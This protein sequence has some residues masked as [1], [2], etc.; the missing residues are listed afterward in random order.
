MR[1]VFAAASSSL[2]RFPLGCVRGGG[3][4]GRI[5]RLV[6]G[7]CVSF[8][9][10]KVMSQGYSS[11]CA[12]ARDASVDGC[13][14]ADLIGNTPL[15]YLKEVSR[16]CGCD[17]FAKAEHMNPF[18]SVKDRAAKE[19]LRAAEEEGRLRPGGTVIEGTGGNTGVS[20]ALLAS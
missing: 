14:V 8:L 7:P 4:G 17:I 2:S 5:P 20:L 13:N 1:K 12:V 9:S 3:V 19:L 10:C 11:S 18:G 15:L 6:V 16:L